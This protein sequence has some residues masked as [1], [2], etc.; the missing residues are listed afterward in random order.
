MSSLILNTKGFHNHGVVLTSFNAQV[1]YNHLETQPGLTSSRRQPLH[2]TW[3]QR[4]NPKNN[5]PMTNQYGKSGELYYTPG[6]KTDL[7]APPQAH[8]D[9]MRLPLLPRNHV[10][11]PASEETWGIFEMRHR[12]LFNHIDVHG[13]FGQIYVSQEYAK[14]GLV[15]TLAKVKK[16]ERCDDGGMYVTVQGIGRFGILDIYAEKPYLQAQVKTFKDYTFQATKTEAFE[17]ILFDEIRYSVKLLQILYPQNNYTMNPSVL[18]YRSMEYEGGI[19]TLLAGGNQMRNV[20]L[21]SKKEEFLRRSK[22]S[23]AT[24]DMLKAEPAIKLSFLQET[25]LETRLIR[26][27]QV[28]TG[29]NYLFPFDW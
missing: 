17:K 11:G 13:I 9:E 2:M 21:A 3:R 12:E 20:H 28:R 27:A 25:V 10:L 4:K 6:G 7:V 23:F 29:I 8:G 16:I 22:F 5:I 26:I 19:E 18:N 15:G 14:L 24:F 1:S